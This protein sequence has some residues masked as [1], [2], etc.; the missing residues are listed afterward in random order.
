M[1]SAT[2]A[3]K[4]LLSG[5][6]TWLLRYMAWI[7][8]TAFLT[9]GIEL[10]LMLLKDWTLKSLVTS[11]MVWPMLALGALLAIPVALVPVGRIFLY[12]AAGWALLYNLIL[13]I[14]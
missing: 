8:V 5:L 13:L 4:T 11:A 6:T 7:G 2:S 10:F 1:A 14:A 9:L 12:T 3:L